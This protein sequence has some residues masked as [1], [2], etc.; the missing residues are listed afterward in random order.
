MKTA[1]YCNHF[2]AFHLLGHLTQTGQLSL[3]CLPGKDCPMYVEAEL[4]C[5]MRQIPLVCYE[6][7]EEQLSNALR[8]HGIDL[9]IV[10]TF[11]HRL[12]G[13]LCQT[14]AHGTWNLHGSPLPAYR[15]PD[16][17]FWQI[18][19]GESKAGLT[20]HRASA[21]IDAGEIFACTTTDISPVEIKG[22]LFDKIAQ[23][24]PDLVSRLIQQLDNGEELKL[25]AQNDKLASE[26]KRPT[27]EDLIIRWDSMDASEVA[28]LIHASNP[29]YGGALTWIRGTEVRMLE[30]ES[31]HCRT[32]LNAKPGCIIH[33]PDDPNLYVVCAKDSYIRVNVLSSANAIATGARL[34]VMFGLRSGEL[35]ADSPQASLPAQA[36][37]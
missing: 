18:R 19:K 25:T 23:L 11:P 9:A 16:P 31:F 4:L 6:D 2:A 24:A 22:S 7:G 29:D 5:R 15:G 35:F 37:C 14:P 33:A 30:A 28:R 27:L 10:F 20:L 34:K 26:Q 17:L 8:E 1:L 13:S 12:S 32:P 36:G 21:R 3:V